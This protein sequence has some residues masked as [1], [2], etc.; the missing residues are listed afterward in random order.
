[1]WMSLIHAATHGRLT[2]TFV[3]TPNPDTLVTL[4]VFVPPGIYESV[5]L[6]VDPVFD[7]APD[8]DTL[9]NVRAAP[10]A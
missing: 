2:T 6:T 5:M 1:M 7:A 9:I 4:N 10:V 8:P 3:P